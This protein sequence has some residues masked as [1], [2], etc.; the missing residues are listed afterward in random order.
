VISLSGAL[1]LIALLILLWL[2]PLSHYRQWSEGIL[3]MVRSVPLPLFVLLIGLLPMIGVP[4]TAMYV[5]AGAV[6][7]PIHGLGM[8]MLGIAIGQL[9]NMALSYAIVVRFHQLGDPLLRRFGVKIPDSQGLPPWKVVL[10]VRA[11]PGAPLMA[12]NVVLGLSG[13]PF[14]CYVLVSLPVEQ[15]I[16]FGYLNAGVSF[17]TGYLGSLML[18][19]G[20]IVVALVAISL[21]RDHLAAKEFAQ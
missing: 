21:L 1:L 12:Q 15:L 10:L 19:V 5:A 2:D 4:V 3:A 13:V 9:L 17:A 7:A 14:G 8:T 11:M 20:V 18:G 6:Y 16:A